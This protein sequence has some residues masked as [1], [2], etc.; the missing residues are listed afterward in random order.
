MATIINSVKG[1]INIG[2]KFF[3]NIH[4]VSI[5]DDGC[6]TIDGKSIEDFNGE[7][8]KV[9]KIE[10]VGNVESIETENA[11]VEVKG[12]AGSIVSKNGN[13]TC[14]DVTGNVDNKNGNIVCGS[15]RGD[16]NT[17]NGNIIRNNFN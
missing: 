12:N 7:E 3:T 1:K 11:D 2:G 17:K 9:F 14:G 15:V 16:V 6:I 5:G 13:V 4:N 8:P 10:V